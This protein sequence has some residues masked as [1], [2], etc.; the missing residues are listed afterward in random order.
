MQFAH[1]NVFVF[2]LLKGKLGDGG[3]FDDDDD[4]D[5]DLSSLDEED[6]REFARTKY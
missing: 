3:D 6:Y 5:F 1:G 4:D 2:V